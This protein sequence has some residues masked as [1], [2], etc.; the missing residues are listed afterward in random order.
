MLIYLR[1]P[2]CLRRSHS[3]RLKIVDLKETVELETAKLKEIVDIRN[4]K[5]ENIKNRT[6]S[7]NRT[8][9]WSEKFRKK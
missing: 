6:A 2:H 3:L 7:K 8:A 9:V 1:T 4:S 5:I